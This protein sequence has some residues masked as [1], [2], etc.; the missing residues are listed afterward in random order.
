MIANERQYKITNSALQ[1]LERAVA[2]LSAGTPLDPMATASAKALESEVEVLRAQIAEYQYLRSGAT[3]AFVVR[4]LSDLPRGLIRARI[5]R[6]LSQRELAESLGLKEQ[7]VQR[8]ESSEYSGA[9]VTRMLEVAAALGLDVPSTSDP[10]EESAAQ[11]RTLSGEID[12]RDFPIKEMYRRHWFGDFQGSL[13]AVI[14]DADYFVKEYIQGFVSRPAI[15]LHRKH[16]RM[17]STLDAYALLAWECRVL[18]LASRSTLAASYSD[19]L[20]DAAW[21]EDLVRLSQY[22]D[23][24]TRAISRLAE[25]G[26]PVVIEP[27]LPGT[28]LDGASLLRDDTPVIGITLRY[29]RLDNFWFVLLHELFHVV[30]HL[31]RGKLT[32]TFDD[33]ESTGEDP[34]ELEADTLAGNALIPGA[35]WSS[36]LARYARTP[37][38]VVSFAQSIERSPAIVAGRIRN[39]ANNYIILSNLVGSRQVRKLFPAIE[40]SA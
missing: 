11:A 16:V 17:G 1:K 34:I 18:D 15:A 4:S 35:E 10:C 25:V 24:P 37:E 27:H 38:S 14:R 30:K 22:E 21:I 8:Y 40:F 28:H 7:Q 12:W 39:E 29:D 6:G 13:D 20:V 5:A 31:R 2:E 3:S 33:L 32:G 9:N 19:G 26:I 23:G 36:A